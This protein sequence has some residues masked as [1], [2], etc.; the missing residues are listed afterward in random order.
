MPIRSGYRPADG[1]RFNNAPLKY[2]RSRSSSN[3]I[4]IN[5]HSSRGPSSRGFA[6]WNTGRRMKSFAALQGESSPIVAVPQQ[7]GTA[8]F[9]GYRHRTSS[10]NNG[11]ESS[12]SSSSSS[13]NSDCDDDL[14][15]DVQVVEPGPSSTSNNNNNAA[16]AALMSLAAAATTIN[17]DCPVSPWKNSSTK[18]KIIEELKDSTS[19][20]QL[21]IGDYTEKAFKDVN[22]NQIHAGYAQRYNKSNFREN[23]KRL[24][25]HKLKGTGP[26]VEEEVK[27]EPWTTRKKRS[28]GWNL[29]Y[30]L[31]MS[32][33]TND[34]LNKM[35]VEEIWESNAH[36]KCYPLQDFKT[37]NADMIKMTDKC[38]KTLEQDV[39][40]FKQDCK[41][42]P[43]NETTDRGEPFW[44]NHRARLLLE[45]DVESGAAQTLKPAELRE[46][47]P[48]YMD[49][50]PKTFRSRVYQ[51][52]DRQRAAPYWQ[53]KRD[54]IARIKIAKER[55]ENRQQWT[56]DRLG[57]NLSRVEL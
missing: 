56:I 12:V 40:D 35:K 26:F 44:Y 38:R 41:N 42:I 13:V 11:D 19:D 57:D 27:L 43:H 16:A 55:D 46:T 15:A 47:R 22:F 4:G 21:Y 10:Y 3:I 5:M 2:Y 36:F 39:E 33:D 17:N 54:K 49:F 52:I 45:K 50:K 29:L 31:R 25:I 34:E 30:G 32:K 48:E 51:E 20:I 8:S 7:F 18:K 28:K 23:F 1:K 37:Y 14:L 6:R 24:L 53:L 9:T